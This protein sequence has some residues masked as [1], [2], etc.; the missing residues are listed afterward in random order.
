MPRRAGTSLDAVDTRT[1][2]G[3]LLPETGLVSAANWLAVAHHLV[4]L[5][6]LIVRPRNFQELTLGSS[7]ALNY[8][9]DLLATGEGLDQR[10]ATFTLVAV[11]CRHHLQDALTLPGFHE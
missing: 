1:V 8:C 9:F 7:R 10:S 11:R 3:F 2:H 6:E 5:S 4:I